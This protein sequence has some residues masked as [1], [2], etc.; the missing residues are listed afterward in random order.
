M[1]HGIIKNL[2]EIEK[3]WNHIFTDELKIIPKSNNILL[4]EPI[5]NPKEQKEK[6]AEYIF[7]T[8]N[9]SKLLI[10]IQP[11]LSLI[12]SAKLSGF[13]IDIGGSMIQMAPII[14]GQ[15]IRYKAERMD[16]GGL[17]ITEYLKNL[18]NNLGILSSTKVDKYVYKDIKEKSCYIALDLE[19]EKNIIEPYIYELP[20]K[21][22]IEIKNQRCECPEILF[23]PGIVGREEEGI[24]KKSYN[25]IEKCTK[26][27]KELYSNIIISGGSSKFNY[28]PERFVKEMKGLVSDSFKDDI[29][30]NAPFEREYSVW[31]GGSIIASL[32]NFDSLCITKSKYE[33]YGPNI[34]HIMTKEY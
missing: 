7:E 24:A 20:D 10:E 4:T 32:S 29:K 11:F 8:F 28:L 2:D 15:F 13:V 16:F 14:E 22:K 26:Y 12:T 30:I 6:E 33:E 21:T 17:D 19:E 3:I 27:Q 18:L 31:I 34:V 1:E 9:F 5:Y 23:K 25:I